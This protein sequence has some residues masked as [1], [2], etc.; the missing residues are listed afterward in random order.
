MLFKEQIDKRLEQEQQHLHEAVGQFVEEVGLQSALK[1]KAAS[2]SHAVREVLAAL[3]IVDDFE[4]D[5]ENPFLTMEEQLA[6]IL[7]PRGIMYRRVELKGKW[8]KMAVG[9]MLGY[10]REG[11]WVALIPTRMKASYTYINKEGLRVEVTSKRMKKDLKPEALCFYPALPMRKIGMGD[12][13]AFMAKSCKRHCPVVS[14]FRLDCGHGDVGSL[15]E[16]TDVRYRDT[17]RYEKRY[18]SSSG[19]ADRGD[20]R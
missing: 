18:P 19:I 2:G 9:P 15:R 10:D 1:G 13:L 20:H 14:C 6:Q 7:N 3:D 17:E 12:L 5:E 8:W 16:Q 4:L 11:K